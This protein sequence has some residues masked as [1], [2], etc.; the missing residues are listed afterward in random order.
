MTGKPISNKEA[1]F[2]EFL[3]LLLHSEHGIQEEAYTALI[4]YLEATGNTLLRIKLATYVD[5][6][7][8]EF[9]LPEGVE[10]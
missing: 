1:L 7:D 10:L 5:A 2:R 6:T 9:Y 3:T 8:G 4:T